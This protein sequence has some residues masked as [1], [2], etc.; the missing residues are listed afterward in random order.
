MVFRPFFSL[1]LIRTIFRHVFYPLFHPLLGL[2][3]SLNLFDRNF[4][5]RFLNRFFVNFFNCY[6][7]HFLITFSN[8]IPPKFQSISYMC[9][10]KPNKAQLSKSDVSS[11]WRKLNNRIL[12][13]LI[14]NT[15][16]NGENLENCKKMKKMLTIQTFAK[17]L[18]SGNIPNLN[19]K[20]LNEFY[21]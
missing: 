10:S 15:P 11:I 16:K 6:F 3:F 8:T 18:T 14:L 5:G 7:A 17:S 9:H 12:F 20:L 2:I 13:R 19:R 4:F 21:Y 1:S